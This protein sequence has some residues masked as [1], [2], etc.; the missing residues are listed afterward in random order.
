[1]A[2]PVRAGQA[3]FDCNGLV[4]D[5]DQLCELTSCCRTRGPQPLIKERLQRRTSVVKRGQKRVD[6]LIGR[7]RGGVLEGQP[8]KGVKIALAPLAIDG[9]PLLPGSVSQFPEQ[10]CELEPHRRFS[11]QFEEPWKK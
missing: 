4:V 7:R 10:K 1:M 9:R 3:S 2:M 8:P 11:S 6:A 5:R